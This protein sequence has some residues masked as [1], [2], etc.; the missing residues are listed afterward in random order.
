MAGGYIRAAPDGA[1]TMAQA[2]EGKKREAEE[3]DLGRTAAALRE[4]VEGAGRRLELGA[5]ALLRRYGLKQ[6]DEEG[7]ARVGH[8]LSRQGIRVK[9]SLLSVLERR[10]EAAEQAG[11]ADP[12]LSLPV[13]KLRGEQ[14]VL[15]RGPALAVQGAVGLGVVAFG[16]G[17]AA[18]WAYGLVV[19]L[20][21]VAATVLVV[22]GFDWLDRRLPPPYPRGRLLGAGVALLVIALVGAVVVL[23]IRS[24]RRA[25]ASAK[26]HVKVANAAIG[27]GDAEGAAKA[28]ELAAAED[29]DYL[30]VVTAQ[31]RLLALQN[32]EALSELDRKQFA[33]RSAVG[34]MRAGD[35]KRAI[36]E[37]RTIKGFRDADRLL[38]QARRGTGP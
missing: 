18:Y 16:V 26:F 23:P 14:L 3:A 8:A 5:G 35:F 32:A 7:A 15:S 4:E 11:D 31:L 2:R 37:L 28:L 27:F 13:A 12:T 17:F 38:D 30:P 34:A 20:A 1:S 24:N 10:A 36:G 33:Y 29:P 22:V 25:E 21:A 9:P 6:L 19:L